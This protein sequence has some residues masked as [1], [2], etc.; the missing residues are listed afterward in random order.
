MAT[1]ISEAL[2]LLAKDPWRHEVGFSPDID[3][4][5]RILFDPKKGKAELEA[6]LASWLHASQPCLFGR[7]AAKIGALV[8]CIL[9]PADLEKSDEDIRDKIQE[10]RLEWRQ[11]AFSGEKSGFVILAISEDIAYATPDHNTLRL[12]QRLTQLYLNK[13]IQPDVLYHEDVLIEKPG[14]GRM[15]WKFLGGVNY[16]SAQGDRRW[17]QDHRIPGGMALSVNSVGH[18]MKS[19]IIG[20]GM[21]ALDDELGVDGDAWN[22]TKIDSPEQALLFAVRTIGKAS[23]AVSGPATK[24]LAAGTDD[25]GKPVTGC[26]FDM[27]EHSDKNCREYQGYY[28]TDITLPNEYF[29]ADVERPGD[30]G[31]HT[32]DFTYIYETNIENPDYF[33]MGVGERVR[34]DEQAQSADARNKKVMRMEPVVVPLSDYPELDRLVPRED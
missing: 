33:T 5:N 9:T 31:L 3:A 22:P 6:A 27:K 18:M 32:L 21:A 17:W 12:A 11:A 20:H 28:H 30:V 24:L 2:R 25:N 1:V 19:A 10:S 34:A 26:P 29:G 15:T 16:F 23:A 14:P 7:M 4:T 8:Y 13:E